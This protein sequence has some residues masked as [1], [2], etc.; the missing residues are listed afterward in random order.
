MTV[1]ELIKELQELESKG[2]GDLTVVEYER[3]CEEYFIVDRVNIFQ[4]AEKDYVEVSS[5]K[6]NKA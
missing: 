1:S 3:S 4:H 6:N 2:N 5:I